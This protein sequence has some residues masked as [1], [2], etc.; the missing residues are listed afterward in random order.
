DG[1]QLAFLARAE[2]TRIWSFP[3]DAVAGKLKEKGQPVTES[4]ADATG[5]D[6][7]PDGTR[8]VFMREN[9]GKH[10]LWAES[11]AEQRPLVLA[12]R[13][14]FRFEPRWSPDG[15]TI[16]YSSTELDCR[17]MPAAGGTEKILNSE[18]FCSDWSP[19]GQWVLASK[20]GQSGESI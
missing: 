8:L 11:L 1:K 16:L 9:G 10:E 14:V 17:S 15:R 13:G 2:Q 18:G 20:R 3:F 19:D 12:D 6:I 7:S 4:G 5:P